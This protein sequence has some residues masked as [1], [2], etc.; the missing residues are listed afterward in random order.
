MVFIFLFLLLDEKINKNNFWHP[1]T[2]LLPNSEMYYFTHYRGPSP[3][4]IP[5]TQLRKL[6]MTEQF[7]EFFPSFS[8]PKRGGPLSTGH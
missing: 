2:K 4:M 3:P 6:L 5:K 1:S 7:P 8:E